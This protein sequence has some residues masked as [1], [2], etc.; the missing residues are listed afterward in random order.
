MEL[1]PDTA[2]L[3][4]FLYN[5]KKEYAG[6]EGNSGFVKAKAFEPDGQYNETSCFNLETR[7]RINL[8]AH[9]DT[10][11]RAGKRADACAAFLCRDVRSINLLPFCDGYAPQH[12]AIRGWP[13]RAGDELQLKAA[14]MNLQQQLAQASS[15]VSR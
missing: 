7:D 11:G 1:Q 14:R 10:H 5:A 9:C 8:W 12:V 15:L 6:Y 13:T 2:P 3:V 4:R